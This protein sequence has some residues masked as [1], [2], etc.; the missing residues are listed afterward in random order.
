[1]RRVSLIALTIL[2]V[3]VCGVMA[4]NSTSL[5][6]NQK[7]DLIWMEDVAGSNGDMVTVE[8]NLSNKA[9]AV[10][11]I[12]LKIDYDQNVMK[13][14]DC[15]KGDLDPNWVMFNCNETAP[16]QITI[17]AFT[18]K[19][20][21]PVDSVGSLVTLNFMVNCKACK[22]GQNSKIVFKSLA[23]DISGFDKHGASLLFK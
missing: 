20:E 12:T 7:A 10:D 4:G 3:A 5:S 11:A 8:V 14:V 1:M 17:G 9:T 16:G 6:T 23:D 18:V 15:E 2:S 13:F 22:S 21:I 19:N